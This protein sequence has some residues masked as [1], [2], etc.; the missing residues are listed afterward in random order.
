M[1]LIVYTNFGHPVLSLRINFNF[2]CL[3]SDCLSPTYGSILAN[4]LQEVSDPY[5]SRGKGGGLDPLAYN[6]KLI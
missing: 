4:K 3:H 6:M 2:M 1:S 5:E